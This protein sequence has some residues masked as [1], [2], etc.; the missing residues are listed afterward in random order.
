[1]HKHVAWPITQSGPQLEEHA[2]VPLHGFEVRA[3][4]AC[5]CRSCCPV[6]SKC[7]VCH[8][9]LMMQLN[10]ST[11][12]LH[13]STPIR[14]GSI[15]FIAAQ[16]ELLKEGIYLWCAPAVGRVTPCCTLHQLCHALLLLHIQAQCVLMARP[17]DFLLL[18]SRNSVGWLLQETLPLRSPGHGTV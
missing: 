2:K 12:L 3:S 15:P 18:G 5:C 1:M 13:N 7:G 8:Q 10:K 16:L 11:T 4:T 6:L 9:Q 17:L 14:A